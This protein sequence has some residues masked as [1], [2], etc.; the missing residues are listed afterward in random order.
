MLFGRDFVIVG[1]LIADPGITRDFRILDIQGVRIFLEIR[2]ARGLYVE[3]FGYPRG[4]KFSDLG[5]I[6]KNGINL[7]NRI[8]GFEIKSSVLS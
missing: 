3:D 2:Y 1:C 6:N 8:K 5:S 7:F 4:L